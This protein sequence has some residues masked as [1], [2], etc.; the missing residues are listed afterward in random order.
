MKASK[1]KVKET[2]L[3]KI[4]GLSQREVEIVSWLEFY[5]KYFFTIKD[6]GQFIKNKQQK[7]NIIKNLLKK[8][9]IVKINNSK[10]YLVPMKAK[11]GGW[12][13]D[14]FK[15]ADEIMDGK[16]Y[17]I[18]G[19]SSANYWR[20]TDQIPFWIEVYSTRRQ[21]RKRIL[22]TGFIFK[23]TTL[24]RTKKAIIIKAKDHTFR[25]MSKRETKKWMKLREYLL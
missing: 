18:G 3:P 20:Y 1:N 14:P 17:Y 15:L 22:N 5:Q 24:N 23:R 9:R 19:W 4:K 2:E 16:D 10:Y 13:E 12:A 7:Y 21:G 6:I 8:K 25:I 11:S